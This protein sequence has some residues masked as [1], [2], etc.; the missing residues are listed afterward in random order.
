MSFEHSDWFVN[1]RCVTFNHAPYIED[2][3][4]GF[5]IQRTT[6]P[7]VATIIDDA[8]TDGVQE[9]IKAYLDAHFDMLQA[10]QWETDD[11]NFIEAHHKENKNC[12]FAVVLLK[13][14]FYSIK[15]DKAPIIKEWTERVNYLA[16]C[17]G[18]D[19]WTDPQKLQKQVEFLENHPDIIVCTHDY[20]KYY[21]QQDRFE[22]KSYYQDFIKE[23]ATKS[24]Y[25]EYSLD[26]YFDRWWTQPLT[27]VYR[28]GAYLSDIPWRKYKYYRDSIFFYY[29]L[30]E[31]KGALL[32]DIIGVYRLHGGG[33]W[34]GHNDMYNEGIAIDNA[35][36]ILEIEGDSRAIKQM[37]K[38]ELH[39][40][41]NLEKEGSILVIIKELF[42]YYKIAP[43]RSFLRMAKVALRNQVGMLHARLKGILKMS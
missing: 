21:Q 30:K 11:A 41:Y 15:K 22:E 33:M 39:R 6:F 37:E 1:I 18:D 27:A 25:I 8:S 20:I 43:F 36:C 5:C 16:Y 23:E 35:R 2:A 32:P 26:N 7:F 14:N 9:V 3:M 34:A 28:N 31:G 10:R 40:I 13:Y 19:Y 38:S 4:N 29:L 12:T 17:E 24:P 42:C